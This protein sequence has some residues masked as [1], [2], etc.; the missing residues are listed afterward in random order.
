MFNTSGEGEHITIFGIT[1][2]GKSTLTRAISQYYHRKII[3]DRMGEWN[4]DPRY[5]VQDFQGFARVYRECESLAD[6]EIVVR[7]R[8]GISQEDLITGFESIC[9]LVYQR[10]RLA[11]LGVLL[12]IEEVWLYSSPHYISPWFKEILLTGRKE[13]ISVVANSQRPASVNKDIPSQSRHVFVGQHFNPNDRMYFR[14][15]LGKEYPKCENLKR[16]EFLWYRPGANE[17]T[18]FKTVPT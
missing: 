4:G 7:F 2:S 5:T 9:N 13:N 14:D 16:F 12:L 10:E 17:S 18:L 3:F 8:P 1:G 15:V 6:F 11:R